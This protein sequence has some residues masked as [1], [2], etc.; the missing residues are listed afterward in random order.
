MKGFTLGLIGI[1][2]AAGI[3]YIMNDKNTKRKMINTG[4]KFAGKAENMVDE[5]LD[6]AEN[7][8]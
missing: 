5:A 4:R 7:M 8:W 3:G 2:T 1:A 6:K